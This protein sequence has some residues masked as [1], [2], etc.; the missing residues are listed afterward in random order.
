MIPFPV[1]ARA[2]RTEVERLFRQAYRNCLAAQWQ[3]A[4]DNCKDWQ[5]I[6]K[7]PAQSYAEEL[8]EGAE[9]YLKIRADKMAGEEISA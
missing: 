8:I 1:P 6:I 7:T 5:G 3:L 4:S 9:V 2:P